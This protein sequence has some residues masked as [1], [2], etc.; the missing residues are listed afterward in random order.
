MLPPR[1]VNSRYLSTARAA[2]VARLVAAG[3]IVV[4]PAACGGG[5]DAEVFGVAT[6]TASGA[7]D[8]ASDATADGRRHDRRRHR[9]HH[10]RPHGHAGHCAGHPAPAA[11]TAPAAVATGATFPAGGEMVIDFTFAAELGG[12]VRNPYVAVWVEDTEGTYVS[13]IV[14]WY[15]QTNKG[16]RYLDDLR[17]WIT[18]SN[19]EVPSTST[20]ATRSPGTYSV[21]WDGTD[22]DGN[23]VSQG[24][25][26]L[27][28]EAAREHGP[29]EITSTPI[30]ISDAGFSV[31]LDD[32][33]ELV[34]LTA[35]LTA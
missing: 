21:V 18:A 17:A 3:A 2:Y 15:E 28:V 26:V 33:G 6:T 24:E 1:Y 35:T 11:T 9:D 22:I 4:V 13:T 32:N 16:M 14:V 25:Y 31:T 30:T 19:G 27:Y 23:L 34:G 8:I 10:G 12:Q 7:T 29:Y 5:G 20:G